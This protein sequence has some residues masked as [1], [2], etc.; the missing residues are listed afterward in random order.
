MKKILILFCLILIT[1]FSLAAS[2]SPIFSLQGLYTA[3]NL[4]VTGNYDF[5]H[6][7]VDANSD[8]ANELFEETETNVSVTN[9]LFTVYLGDQN[10]I[11][12]I[13]FDDTLWLETYVD[14]VYQ[15]RV[16]FYPRIADV[17][18][19]FT[20][21]ATGCDYTSPVDA[22]NAIGAGGGIIHLADEVFTITEAIVL[23][24]SVILEGEGDGTQIK[25]GANDINA[26]ELIGTDA[27]HKVFTTIKD[28][29]ISGSSRGYTSNGIWLG[30]GH[31]IYVKDVLFYQID[32]HGLVLYDIDDGYFNDLTLQDVGNAGNAK[33]VISIQTSPEDGSTANYFS[34]IGIEANYFHGIALEASSAGNKFVNFKVHGQLPTPGDYYGL[35]VASQRNK[36]VN[37][38]IDQFGSLEGIRVTGA[39]NTFSNMNVFTGEGTGFSAS[40][41][42]VNTVL[43]NSWI[44]NITAGD[45]VHLMGND[46]IVSNNIVEEADIGFNIESN[47]ATIT[48]N[49]ASTNGEHGFD[50]NTC[51]YCIVSNNIA[52]QNSQSSTNSFSGFYVTN[53]DEGIYSNN[54]S[55]DLQGTKTQKHGLEIVSDSNYNSFIGNVMM[56]S[57]NTANYRQDQN[58]AANNYEADNVFAYGGQG[59]SVAVAIAGTSC[60]D[61]AFSKGGVCKSVVDIDNLTTDTCAS[62]SDT[63]MCVI[64]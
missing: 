54:V 46:S 20:V 17:P 18:V 42:A 11:T 52:F 9:G 51:D 4:Y 34:N 14:D 41:T 55:K 12:G 24:S 7:L 59:F 6:I 62:T 53:S 36:F 37:G 64:G 13:D 22:A 28:L 27:S 32:G 47:R 25:I 48:G 5:K 40:G 21:C 10:D 58:D 33:D 23:K 1:S 50:L 35:L 19:K 31:R 63:R 38:E 43:T 61:T 49:N 15:N 16:P 60:N 29:T 45:G 3:N 30:Y 26:I 44:Y 57:G 39:E 8:G 2:Y 56:N